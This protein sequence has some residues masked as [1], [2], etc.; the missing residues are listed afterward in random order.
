MKTELIA[1]GPEP[2]LTWFLEELAE[3]NDPD[4]TIEVD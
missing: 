2:N 1:S 3:L 4:V